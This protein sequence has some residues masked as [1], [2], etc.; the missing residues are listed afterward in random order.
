MLRTRTVAGSAVGFTAVARTRFWFCRAHHRVYGCGSG[1]PHAVYIL[2]LPHGLPRC[3]R[4]YGLR[5]TFY[6]VTHT[7]HLHGLRFTVWLRY[8]RFSYHTFATGYTHLPFTAHHTAT[9]LVLGSHY[10]HYTLPFTLPVWVLQF[11]H[12]YTYCSYLLVAVYAR[13]RTTA[14]VTHGYR[15]CRYGSATALVLHAAHTRSRL[16][17]VFGSHAVLRF[18]LRYLLHGYY[19][20][21]CC[22]SHTIPHRTIRTHTVYTRV[23]G[24]ALVHARGYVL[25]AV[26]F[27]VLPRGLRFTGSAFTWMRFARYTA[28]DTVHFTVCG[29]VYFTVFYLPHCCAV[30]LVYTRLLHTLHTALVHGYTHA[31]HRTRFWVAHGL[32]CTP[33]GSA[34][35]LHLLRLPAA[36]HGLRFTLL[37]RT[38]FTLLHTRTHRYGSLHYRAPFAV[39]YGLRSSTHVPHIHRGYRLRYATHRVVWVCRLLHGL[40]FALRFTT[41]HAHATLHT[42]C[43]RACAPHAHTPTLHYALRS[44]YHCGWFTAPPF[45][46]LQ[47][48]HSYRSS[49]SGFTAPRSTHRCV[50]PVCVTTGLRRSL[51]QL[52]R[53]TLLPVPHGF[54]APFTGYTPRDTR[55]A[56]WFH[57]TVLPFC[58]S[59]ALRFTTVHVR[60]GCTTLLVTHLRFCL[61]LLRTTATLRRLVCSAALRLF[62][63]ITLHV[64]VY[65][66]RTTAARYAVLRSHTFTVTFYCVTYYS[67]GFAV[68][69]RFAVYC[70]HRLHSHVTALP[71]AVLRFAFGCTRFTTHAV[72]AYR[73]AH[74]H[75]FTCTL[76]RFW[77]TPPRG[78]GSTFSC[79][80]AL[81]PAHCRIPHRTVYRTCHGFARSLQLRVPP[82]FT[83][84]HA[85]CG[86]ITT[87]PGS[88][89]PVTP[90]TA[91]YRRGLVT[92]APFVTAVAV[93]TTARTTAYHAPHH[94]VT[95]CFYRGYARSVT[96]PVGLPFCGYTTRVVLVRLVWFGYVHCWF[97]VYGSAFAVLPYHTVLRTTAVCV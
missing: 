88:T 29:S 57:C 36:V 8:V 53:T 11:T 40:R 74:T 67:Y 39:V 82:R 93:A 20:S 96:A 10:T 77:F 30:A 26:R 71:F 79:R 3:Y 50:S 90:F 59:H 83:H 41:V 4:F 6:T 86:W 12:G 15:A 22:G 23:R 28:C 9:T 52:L 55:F 85:H 44:V 33:H 25:H 92:A 61:P 51:L 65:T 72:T 68:G 58:G 7:V 24:Y 62:A 64:L 37:P 70:A 87:L 60:T 1:L 94:T 66:P 73:T 56:V 27:C 80:T 75:T 45:A 14:V 19:G 89:T 95:G 16:H 76:L 18:V 63:V 42:H 5:F 35:G 84:T 38:P 21:V 91:V 31:P 17:C 47:F 32:H 49:G 97:T 46:A 43:T 34:T 13:T 48:A 81:L 69:L 54:A 2:R 78:S